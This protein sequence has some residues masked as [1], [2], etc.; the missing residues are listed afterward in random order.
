MT[1]QSD[2]ERIGQVAREF[3]GLAIDKLADE[4]GVHAETVIAGVA[5]MAGTFLFRLFG[6]NFPDAKAGQAVLSEAANERGPR[7]V[8][9]LGTILVD[10]GIHPDL[11]NISDASRKGHEPLLAFLETQ[12]RLEP[13]FASV[14][15]R[16]GLSLPQAADAAA[17]ATAM[18]I[19]QTVR[20][21]DP[22]LA[23]DIAVYSFIEGTKTV[24]AKV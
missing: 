18:L 10:A 3:A 14:R 4:Q 9:L 1:E 17:L 8:N 23:F 15:E 13:A 11:N 19:Q 12:R 24:P 21:L 6:V 5:R 2:P 16:F 22:D 20:V 7:L